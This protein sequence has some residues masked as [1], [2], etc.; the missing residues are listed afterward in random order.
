MP[1]LKFHSYTSQINCPRRD[2]N[3]HEVIDDTR[4]DVTFVLVDQDF[5]A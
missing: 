2:V 5:L 1:I 3:V 4:L